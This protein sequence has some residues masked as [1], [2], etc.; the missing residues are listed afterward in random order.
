MR[1]IKTLAK[2]MLRPLANPAV[3]RL[4]EMAKKEV[5]SSLKNIS[6]QNTEIK[7]L[8]NELSDLESSA[9]YICYYHGG[10]GNHGCEALV[11][12]IAQVCGMDRGDLGVYSYR[13]NEDREF[14]LLDVA[15][16]FRKSELDTNEL[17]VRFRS[18]TIALSIGGDNYCGYPIP[19]LA[20]YNRLFHERG[21]KT[22]LIGCSIEPDNLEHSEIMGDLCQ[23]DL[24]TA[25]ETIT[26]DALVKKGISK[27]KLKL[28]PD[29][30]FLLPVADSK[31]KLPPNTIGFNLSNMVKDAGGLLVYENAKELIKN[32]LD[33]TDYKVALIPHVAQDFN[34]DAE[35]LTRLYSDFGKNSRL[36]LIPKT[37]NCQQIKD[38][39]RQCVIVVAARTHCSIAAYSSKIP[40]LVLGYSVKSRGIALDLFGECEHYVKSVYGLK[41]KSEFW[42]AFCWLDNNKTMIQEHLNRRIPEY[43]KDIS[44]LKTYVE[45]LDNNT[46]ECKIQK[47]AQKAKVDSY[48]KGVLSIITTCY[49]SEKYLY[50]YFDSILKQTNHNIQLIVVNDGSIDNTEK[51]IKNYAPIF[52]NQNIELI[53]LSQSNGGIGSAYDLAMKYVSGEYFC[54]CDS[55]NFYAPNFAEII[56]SYMSTH[57]E[58]KILRHDGLMISESKINDAKFDVSEGIKFSKNSPDPYKKDLFMNAILEKNWHFGNAVISTAAFD[59][60]SDR[61]I[62]PSRAG[63]NWQLCLPVLY[64]YEAE[65]IPDILFYCVLRDNSVSRE[66]TN[67]V[68]LLYDQMDE[69]KNILIDTIKKIQPTK[70]KYLLDLIE[71]KYLTIKEELARAYNDR[72]MSSIFKDA[73]IENIEEKGDIYQNEL[74]RLDS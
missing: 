72:E 19:Q 38:V 2:K 34:D 59:S 8:M 1:K 56:L 74:K 46:L 39:I 69:Y 3:S 21:A 55:D 7:D 44:K 71:Q 11:R 30:A 33:K 35:I 73:L 67:S 31:I 64:K 29:T 52:K 10:S 61:N 23:F 43:I 20:K 48:K 40:T 62:F 26:Y 36:I 53:Y 42:E 51:I 17:P 47:V 50:R 22:A 14:G 24:I 15:S 45:G 9:K 63:Q 49:N 32:I 18:G 28:I 16:F 12:T 6:S 5:D 54:W 41:N 66:S 27:D 70:Q 37:L 4:R 68:N 13:P 60:V 58:T 25:R 65:Y 57:P